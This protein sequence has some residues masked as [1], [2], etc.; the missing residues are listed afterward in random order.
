MTILNIVL[1]FL[2]VFDTKY[3]NVDFVLYLML[4]KTNIYQRENSK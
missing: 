4:L 1:N 3:V 2:K